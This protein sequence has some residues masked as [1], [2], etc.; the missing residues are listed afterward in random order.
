MVPLTRWLPATAHG[1]RSLLPTSCQVRSVASSTE[2]L[3]AA[4]I[5]SEFDSMD[6]RRRGP[7]QQV[8][9]PG[10]RSQKWPTPR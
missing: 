1:Q 6:P 8:A 10:V 5:K 2:K 7:F 9:S 4:A 3:A